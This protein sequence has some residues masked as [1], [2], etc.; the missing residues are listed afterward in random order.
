MIESKVKGRGNTLCL[1]T[2][3]IG[4][5]KS[6]SKHVVTGRGVTLGPIKHSVTVCRPSHNYSHPSHMQNTLKSISGTMKFSSNRALNS[7]R[8]LQSHI[9]RSNVTSLDLKTLSENIIYLPYRNQHKMVKQGQD[10]T[11]NTSIQKGEKWDSSHLSI[12]IL[13]SHCKN[14]VSFSCSW[15]RECS[16]IRH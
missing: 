7:T 6:Q 15:G 3:V 13:K 9:S 4:T 10:K 1:L 8:M 16:F 12:E 11:V 14:V 5:T 2:L